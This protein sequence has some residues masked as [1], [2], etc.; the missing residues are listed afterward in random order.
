MVDPTTLNPPYQDQRVRLCLR[1]GPGFN[2]GAFIT[3]EDQGQFICDFEDCAVSARF[4][5]GPV[6]RFPS[7]DQGQDGQDNVMYITSAPRLVTAL[8][9]SKTATFALR[10][11]EAGTQE[12]SFS[13]AGLN[14]EGGV[15][16]SRRHRG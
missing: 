9:R 5:S 13:V 3:L 1:S 12:I 11:Y 16:P 15:V 4:D 6:Q 7:N 14:W 2:A 10:F 8:K